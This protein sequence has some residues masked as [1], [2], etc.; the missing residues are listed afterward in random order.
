MDQKAIQDYIEKNQCW[1]CGSNNEHGL[2]LKSYFSGDESVC[3][4][5]PGEY[6]MAGPRH[7]LNGGIIATIIDCHSICT[8]IADAHRREGREL[9][10][11]P[12][13]W[14]VTASLK[15]DYLRP[16]P[17]GE[18]VTLRASVKEIKGKKSIVECALFAENLERVRA[19]VIAVRVPTADWYR[20]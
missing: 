6:H 1:G 9:S 4:W 13:I 17:I 20:E 15:V 14:Y 19:E 12:L 7:F 11:E 3:T 5:K 18:S 8:A 10:T 2:H 16:T